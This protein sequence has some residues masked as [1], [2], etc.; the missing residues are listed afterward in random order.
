MIKDIELLIP[1]L[2][3]IALLTL[4]ERKI[5]GSIQRRKG[6]NIVGIYGI[7]QPFSDGLKSILKENILPQ[8][9]TIYYIYAPFIS[10]IISLLLWAVIPFNINIIIYDINYSLLLILAITSISIYGI[11]YGGW[12]SK[13]QWS[14][15]GTLRATSQLISYEISLGFILFSII[16]L[17]SSF[18]LIDIL[19]NQIYI[20]N[21][22]PLLPISLLLLISILAETNRTPFDLLEAESELVAGFLVE[23]S[24]ISFLSYY[25]AEYSII[26]FFSKLFS[27][28]FL[29]DH[30]F[31]LPLFLIIWIRASL[32]RLKYDQLIYMGWMI[33]LPHSINYYLSLFCLLWAFDIS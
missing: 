33:I 26:L 20:W 5:M 12:S 18:N 2:I 7:L 31:I 30:F 32:P 15:I 24:S 11:L 17:N 28:L 19:Y 21:I 8:N 6:P 10:L 27:I 3:S 14:M 29:A 13:S 1:I 4:G 25:L 22:I 16:T 23:Y 9:T